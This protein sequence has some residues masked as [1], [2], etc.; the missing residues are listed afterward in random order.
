MGY[1]LK[2]LTLGEILD[3][4]FQILGEHFGTLF[5]IKVCTVLPSSIILGIQADAMERDK[6]APT[7]LLYIAALMFYSLVV[8]PLSHAAALSVISR[9]Y[10]GHSTTLGESFELGKRRLGPLIVTGIMTL[11]VILGGTLLFIIPGILCGIWFSL[12]QEVT[13]LE[14]VDGETALGRSKALIQKNMGTSILLGIVI[15]LIAI[16]MSLIAK[17]FPAPINHL[18]SA[19][20]ACGLGM[21]SG[22]VWSV[23]YFSC[24]CDDEGF[25]AEALAREIAVEYAGKDGISSDRAE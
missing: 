25:G 22:C 11:I 3:R 7:L 21:L 1:E 14:Q 9:C 17:I 13:L 20:I 18:I 8:G 4:G 12:V 15:V 19:M 2:K 23:F 5:Q 10:L 16:P 24:R 6:S